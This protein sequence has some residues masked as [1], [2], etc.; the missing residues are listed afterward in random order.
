MQQLEL[1]AT[2]STANQVVP[3]SPCFANTSA[4]IKPFGNTLLDKLVA[5]DTREQEIRETIDRCLAVSNNP[6][7][8]ETQNVL[9]KSKDQE[10][11]AQIDKANR[12]STRI[13][14]EMRKNIQFIKDTEAKR[15]AS[16]YKPGNESLPVQVQ[17]ELL[18]TFQMYNAKHAEDRFKTLKEGYKRRG[19]RVDSLKEAKAVAEEDKK[20]AESK[21][22]TLQKQLTDIGKQKSNI[23]I[24]LSK[25]EWDAGVWKR[26]SEMAARKLRDKEEEVRELIVQV[27][28]AQD[29][30]SELGSVV[31]ESDVKHNRFVA[32]EEQTS[33]MKLSLEATLKDVKDT[34][35]RCDSQQS[36]VS[37]K[38]ENMRKTQAEY[39]KTMNR[40]LVWATNSARDTQKLLE[41][42]HK[43]RSRMETHSTDVVRLSTETS[44]FKDRLS[45]ADKDVSDT[46][47]QVAETARKLERLE[48]E[49][50]SLVVAN[51]NTESV[52]KKDKYEIQRLQ[53]V[54]SKLNSDLE[55]KDG[56]IKRLASKAEAGS[57]ELGEFRTRKDGHK[58]LCQE[59]V[60]KSQAETSRAVKA[61]DEGRILKNQLANVRLELQGSR[62]QLLTANKNMA[63][64]Q[65]EL[66]AADRRLSTVNDET[67]ELK[68]TNETQ[69][70]RLEELMSE[71][72]R[73]KG[74][75]D[76]ATILRGTLRQSSTRKT[77]EIR[78][79]RG[80]SDLHVNLLGRFTEALASSYEE[81]HELQ[82]RLLQDVDRL[83]QEKV[84]DKGQLDQLQGQINNL[85]TEKMKLRRELNA[86]NGQLAE[87]RQALETE[88]DKHNEVKATLLETSKRHE[89]LSR[90]FDIIVG[91][92]GATPDDFARHGLQLS[93]LTALHPQAR[94]KWPPPWLD[95]NN[96]AVSANRPPILGQ[97]ELRSTHIRI[98]IQLHKPLVAVSLLLSVWQTLETAT[99]EL[100]ADMLLVSLGTLEEVMSRVPHTSVTAL[101][102]NL[103][104][105]KILTLC[106]TVR[107]C[108][109][110]GQKTRQ[111]LADFPGQLA[112][113]SLFEHLW[114]NT[115]SRGQD[116]LFGV[117]FK[118][119][120]S[121]LRRAVLFGDGQSVLI[122][123]ENPDTNLMILQLEQMSLTEVSL[124]YLSWWLSLGGVTPH[125]IWQ[126]APED[127]QIMQDWAD[128]YERRVDLR[129]EHLSLMFIPRELQ[130]LY[131]E[132]DRRCEL[133]LGRE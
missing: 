55:S 34:A 95:W 108:D 13:A 96:S 86:A 10:V 54:E 51:Q 92:T 70:G 40:T 4:A 90:D 89:D 73:L 85:R 130:E 67:L 11:S 121:V 101:L 19:D 32:Q 48:Q 119:K 12:E 71:N 8:E 58:R 81:K 28:E 76:E 88:A 50:S 42:K 113:A 47:H 91:N 21:V 99:F 104:A 9:L 18:G 69:S 120:D 30:L 6:F 36:I 35:S 83:N 63:K 59:T 16:E 107:P 29:E 77:Y 24:T 14:E 31:K 57:K 25:L 22:L 72:V 43:L 17:M 87:S 41:Q 118:D 100:P 117:R 94:D 79:L 37:A 133:T 102:S 74:E 45:I 26:D 93:N 103:L 3:R 1:S 122:A 60:D 75:L 53:E 124:C 125:S 15:P 38:L 46:I 84:T 111:M 126:V 44:S 98:L 114:A 2:T 132:I 106:Q 97:G 82:S 115:T 65:N 52:A 128:L 7:V 39:N 62:A 78:T 109:M 5:H 127:S 123:T 116:A 56:S 49:F 129:D 64:I 27:N 105:R 33:T 112:T 20:R 61:E 66:S 68:S 110:P 23:S 80:K 131:D